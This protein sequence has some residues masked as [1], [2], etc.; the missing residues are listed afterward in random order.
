MVFLLLRH[1]IRGVQ[2]GGPGSFCLNLRHVRNTNQRKL[3]VGAGRPKGDV[4]VFV[5]SR[6]AV[7]FAALTGAASLGGCADSTNQWFSKP[8][9][10]FGSS[11]Y[12]YSQ[13]DDVKFDRPIGANDLVEANGTCP[14]YVPVASAPPQPPPTAPANPG[15]PPPPP[16]PSLF[17]GGVALGMSECEVVSHLGQPTAVNL[18]ANPNGTRSAVL[19]FNSGPRPGVYRFSSGHLAEMDRVAVPAP[20][21]EPERKVAKKKPPKPAGTQ[22]SGD[23]S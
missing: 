1:P 16:D 18:G 10:M 15:E 2:W 7:A 20:P 8:L 6:F 23:K 4:P 5:R 11:G 17:S 14:R 9:N 13:L 19:T 21:P 22:P 12:T 3:R